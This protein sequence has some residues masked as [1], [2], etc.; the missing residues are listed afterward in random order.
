MAML[1]LRVFYMAT[2][3]NEAS[4]DVMGLLSFCPSFFLS[5]FLYCLIVRGEVLDVGIYGSIKGEDYITALYG[6]KISLYTGRPSGQVTEDCPPP[7]LVL[8]DSVVSGR[9]LQSVMSGCHLRSVM[10]GRHLWS[11]ISGRPLF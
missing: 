11:V 2:S 5:F 8:G 3:F 9:H 10:S 7:E 1:F 4:G 6:C